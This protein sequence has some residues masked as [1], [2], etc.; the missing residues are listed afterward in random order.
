MSV[1]ASTR[2]CILCHVNTQLCQSGS[3]KS[4]VCVDN[5]GNLAQKGTRPG[6]NRFSKK[7]AEKERFNSAPRHRRPYHKQR[8]QELSSGGQGDHSPTADNCLRT[9]MLERGFVRSR[10]HRDD[11]IIHRSTTL[12]EKGS[13]CQLCN[14]PDRVLQ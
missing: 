1:H 11:Y 13:Y 4:L 6:K 8:G 2:V 12:H 5:S 7:T 3:V 10:L 9:D 14:H